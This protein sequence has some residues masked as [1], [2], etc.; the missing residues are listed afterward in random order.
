VQR[1]FWML[2]PH[3]KT[4]SVIPANTMR[5]NA[6]TFFAASVCVGSAQQLSSVACPVELHFVG[7][8][9]QQHNSAECRGGSAVRQGGVVVRLLLSIDRR[10]SSEAALETVCNPRCKP[11]YYTDSTL[12]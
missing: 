12:P 4:Y 11:L 6:C 8:N 2:L 1:L 5:V 10:E 3:F 7:A 9:H